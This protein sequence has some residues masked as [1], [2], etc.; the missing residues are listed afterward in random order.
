MAQRLL[1]S[2]STND[3]LNTSPRP[4]DNLNAYRTAGNDL[5]SNPYSTLN[6]FLPK[7]DIVQANQGK[8]DGDSKLVSGKTT[9]QTITVDG[10]ER[11]YDVHTP[12]DWDGKTPLP[13][14]YYFNGLSPAGREKESFTGLS[15]RADREHFAVVYMDGAGKAHTYNNGQAVFDDGMDENKYLNAVH[16][17]LKNNLPIAADY[18]G[19]AGFSE[20]GSEALDL[21]SKNQWVSSV[22]TV[23]GYATDHQQALNRPISAQLINAMNDTIVPIGGTAAVEANAKDSKWYSPSHIFNAA[24]AAIEDHNNVIEPQSYSINK[25]TTADAASNMQKVETKDHDEIDTY[26]NST[27]GVEVKA[28]KLSTGTHGWAGSTDHSG[29]IHFMNLGVPNETYNASDAIAEFFLKHPI[30]H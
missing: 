8:P 16:D 18:Q 10:K 26:R 3:T 7:V 20:G 28:V 22:Q 6:Y 5:P 2:D 14:L 9:H 12:K 30:G 29:D 23:E 17:K 19:L 25:F 11:D 13:V 4:Q 1:P 21:A 15:Q 27:S 24:V